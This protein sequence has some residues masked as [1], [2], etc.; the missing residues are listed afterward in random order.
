MRNKIRNKQVALLTAKRK[1]TKRLMVI[2]RLQA[3]LESLE[4]QMGRPGN[5]ASSSQDFDPLA[6][7]NAMKYPGS[8]LPTK[9]ELRKMLPDKL[10]ELRK[11]F[12]DI[13]NSKQG[14]PGAPMVA[15]RLQAQLQSLGSER[16]SSSTGESSSQLVTQH[17]DFQRPTLRKKPNI[18]QVKKAGSGAKNRKG[19]GKVL[20]PGLEGRNIWSSSQCVSTQAASQGP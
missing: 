12:P 10:Q 4:G 8:Q 17:R 19:K 20:S 13:S 5:G 9:R 2:V 11:M 18:L 16:G 15:T 14:G 7:C 1:R 3:Q 6:R